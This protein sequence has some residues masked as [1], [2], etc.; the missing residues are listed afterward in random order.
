MT[1][2]NKH[3]DQLTLADLANFR[4]KIETGGSDSTAE[5]PPLHGGD[6]KSDK[7]LGLQHHDVS[8]SELFNANAKKN[9]DQKIYMF[10]ESFN[11]LRREL[12]DNWPN[13]W[14]LVGYRMAFRA[15]EFVEFMNGAL[16]VKLVLDSDNVDFI[17]STYLRKLKQLRGLSG[18]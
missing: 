16:D 11:A 9:F 14:A 7:A 5:S 1:S 13:L 2:D 8:K 10:P 15:D 18:D 12:H 6:S 4:K 17:C 3:P